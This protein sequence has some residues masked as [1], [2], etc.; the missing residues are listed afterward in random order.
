M[1]LLRSLRKPFH[2]GVERDGAVRTLEAARWNYAPVHA[3]EETATGE[4]GGRIAAQVEME[5]ILPRVV[6]IPN[7]GV[8]SAFPRRL[9]SA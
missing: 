9:R 3:G 5:F 7:A 4:V 8:D 1:Q 2:L 6:R